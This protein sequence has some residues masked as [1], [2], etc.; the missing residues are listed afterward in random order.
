LIYDEPNVGLDFLE[1]Q[2]FINY[3]VKKILAGHQIIIITHD[4][5]FLIRLTRSF[6]VLYKDPIVNSTILGYQGSILDFF[7]SKAYIQFSTLKIPSELIQLVE[8]VLDKNRKIPVTLANSLK[9][10]YKFF[11]DLFL[12]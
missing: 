11:N 8:S 6:I 2:A 3:A 9:D 7:M 5:K 10:H 1:K 12:V 4:I